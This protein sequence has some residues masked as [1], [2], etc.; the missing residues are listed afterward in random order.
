MP[1]PRR[2][3]LQGL[4]AAALGALAPAAGADEPPD[5]LFVAI[6]DLNDWVGVLGGHVQ[7][8]TPN[9][10]RLAARGTLFTNA[11]CAAPLCNPSRTAL[12]TGRRPSTTGIY[13]NPQPFRPVMPD[14]VTLPEA[15]GRAGW[16]TQACG[17]IFHRGDPGAFEVV[18][19]DAC[20]LPRPGKGWRPRRTP[21][22]GLDLR[23]HFDWGRAASDDD[24]T[25]SD[26]RVAD[27]VIDWL[28]TP[29]RGPRFLACGFFRPHLPWY[30]PGRW[31]DAYP[32]RDIVLP[33]VKPD[34]LDDVPATG[35]RL[36]KIQDHARIVAGDQWAA[37]VQGYLA[38]LSFADEQLGRVIDALDRSP[39]AARTVIVLWA[40]HG[41]SLGEKQHWKKS[42]LWEEC[43]RVPLV[44]VAPG[45][46]RPGTTSAR[47]VNLLDV[48]PTLVELCGVPAPDGLEGESLV[49]LLHDPA[50]PRPTPSLTT[51]QRGNHALRDDRWRYIR[52]AD[53]GEELY[54]HASDPHEWVNRADDPTAAGPKARLARFLPRTDAPD[55]PMLPD[56][57]DGE[58]EDD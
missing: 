34:D 13:Q 36:A 41:W 55:A 40:D 18:S 31:F 10:D 52:Y 42:A 24:A 21:A 58:A 27:Q 15:F 30:V 46:T 1:L 19:P 3:F 43:T 32:L 7:A 11:H 6:D 53:G 23:G 9:I 2:R 5:V 50:A 29:G 26:A 17:K 48:Y 8:R 12:L 16:R 44:V 38:S 56:P 28:G 39:R 54:D 47:A 4:G 20:T 49:P 22:N 37:A 14:V 33:V 45:V 51:H 25:Q 35:R 57:C